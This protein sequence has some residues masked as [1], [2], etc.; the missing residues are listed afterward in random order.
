MCVRE[1]ERERAAGESVCVMV[2]ERTF[3]AGKQEGVCLQ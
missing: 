3:V 1:R 2:D